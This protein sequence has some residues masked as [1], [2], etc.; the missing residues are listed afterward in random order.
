MCDFSG[1]KVLH[2]FPL[3]L[4]LYC[5]LGKQGWVD[6]Y[7]WCHAQQDFLEGCLLMSAC[8]QGGPEE[9]SKTV[10]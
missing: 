6:I 1:N 10:V 7:K 5:V 3:L 8:K 4:C 9:K 2:I